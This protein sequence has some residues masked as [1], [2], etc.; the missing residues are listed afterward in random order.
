[1]TLPDAIEARGCHC[2]GAPHDSHC[3]VAIAADIRSGAMGAEIEEEPLIY[4]TK[5]DEKELWAVVAHRAGKWYALQPLVPL[6]PKRFPFCGNYEEVV[7]RVQIM[8]SDA[9]FRARWRGY[10]IAGARVDGQVMA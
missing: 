1:M 5:G 3:P 2:K 6:S 9:A 8:L 7:D 4:T 10:Y